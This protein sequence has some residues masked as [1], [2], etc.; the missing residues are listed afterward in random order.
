[1]KQKESRKH[2][3]K[4][5]SISWTQTLFMSFSFPGKEQSKMHALPNSV[6][7]EGRCRTESRVLPWRHNPPCL[8]IITGINF[9]IFVFIFIFVAIDSYSF[10]GTNDPHDSFFRTERSMSMNV[11]KKRK[12]GKSVTVRKQKV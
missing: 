3:I 11:R 10:L 2:V 4:S 8:R 12:K 7:I 6:N 1:M 5:F 9:F